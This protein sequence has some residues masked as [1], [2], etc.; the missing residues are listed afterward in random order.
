MFQKV[1]KNRHFPKGIVHGFCPKIELFF[2]L[3][4]LV[5]SSQK[6]WFFD[7]L[8]RK[9]RFLDRKINVLKSAKGHNRLVLFKNRTS[10]HLVFL[11]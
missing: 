8:D 4:F 6:R 2:Y 7:I 11:V 5:Y 10:F 9:G 1:P 3:G